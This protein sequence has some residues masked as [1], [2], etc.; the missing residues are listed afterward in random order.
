MHI[1]V[2]GMNHTTASVEVRECLAFNSDALKW[3]LNRLKPADRSV[4]YCA[5][6]VILS[7]C[8]RLEIYALVDSP[9]SGRQRLCDFLASLHQVS[10]AEFEPYLYTYVDAQAVS[11]L[12][13]VAAGLDSMVLG[14]A[15][16]LGQVTLA[17]QSALAE[18]TVGPVLSHLFRRAIRAGKRARTET[19]I[20]QNAASVSFA[21]VQMAKKIYGDLSSR[22]VLVVGAGATGELVAKTLMNNGAQGII[23]AN[24]TYDRAL[25]LAQQWQGKA[26]KFDQLFEAL[27]EA[28]IVITATDAP[29]PIIRAE[30]VYQALC[31]RDDRPLFFIDIAVPRDVEA[32]VKH[33]PNVHYYDIDDLDAVIAANIEERRREIPKVEAIIREETALF[34]EWFRSLNV[35]P[36]IAGLREFAESVR[37]AE[38]QKALRRMNGISERERNIISALSVGIVNKLLHEPTVRLRRNANGHDGFYYSEAIRELF[39]LEIES[40]RRVEGKNDAKNRGVKVLKRAITIGTRGSALALTQTNLVVDR[41]KQIYP[42][43]SITVEIIKTQ[44]D[45]LPHVSLGVL[46]GKGVFVKELEEV[47]LS[48]QIYLAVH[49]LKDLPTILPNGL[50]IGAVLERADPRDVL[51]SRTGQTLL[52]LPPGARIGTGSARRGLQIMQ[53]RP[54][55]ELVD[56][57]GNVDT[58]LRKLDSGAYD[59]LILAAAGLSRMGLIE[60]ATEFFEPEVILPAPGQGALALEVRSDDE[61]LLDLIAALDDAP[62]HMAVLAERAFLRGLG[63]GCQLPIAAYATT[64]GSVVQLDGLLGSEDR[65]RILQGYIEG[66]IEQAELLGEQLAERLLR[67]GGQQMWAS[68]RST[69]QELA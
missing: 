27:L 65:R 60:R 2:I 31:A 7:T 35:V 47:L 34:N 4:G 17:Y 30:M 39:G 52:E 32:A 40:E 15:Q 53:I 33:L 67:R 50:V 58:R 16:V 42:D 63:G 5:E 68:V 44:G 23:V 38:L 64:N 62:T 9:E 48:C 49:S 24:R 22:V 61:G 3:A 6:G 11:H 57:R 37:Q 14:E 1:I 8:N 51:V 55:V 54:D 25:Q 28:D 46:G 12:C 43:L 18:G 45:A 41:L 59:A 29:H 69:G 10:Y 13:S 19:A 20:G 36:M 21:A 66:P 56:I 26:F